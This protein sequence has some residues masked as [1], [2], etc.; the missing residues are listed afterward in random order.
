MYCRHIVAL[1]RFSILFYLFGGGEHIK[2]LVILFDRYGTFLWVN[3][4][5]MRKNAA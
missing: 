4:L 2:Y 3:M 5:V 1:K